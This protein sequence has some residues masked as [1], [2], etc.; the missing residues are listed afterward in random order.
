MHQFNR[1]TRLLEKA[2]PK[3]KVQMSDMKLPRKSLAK[4]SSKKNSTS[5]V[6][7]NVLTQVIH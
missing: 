6:L 1:K 3:I 4:S 2:T 5:M 7:T